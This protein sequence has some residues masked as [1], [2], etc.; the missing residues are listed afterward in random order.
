[1]VTFGPR[2]PDSVL[3]MRGTG[4][5][6]FD[7]VVSDLERSLAFYR[8]LLAPLGYVRA[9]EIVGERGERVVYL[10]ETSDP[11]GAPIESDEAAA[12]RRAS[13]AAI[14]VRLGFIAADRAVPDN[15]AV[16]VLAELLPADAEIG[17]C[18]T[19]R[20][21]ASSDRH[22]FAQ[23]TGVF[24]DVASFYMNQSVAE[25]SGGQSL[26]KA[27]RRELV[28]CTQDALCW[29]ASR[30]R[31]DR[32]DSVTLYSVPFGDILGAS[33]RHRRRGVVE[34][35]ID[36]GP[37]LSFRVGPDTADALKTRIDRAAQSQ[38]A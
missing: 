27:P 8:A 28:V 36:D 34:V 26:L 38:Q 23:T 1:L 14:L 19:C 17:L 22:P 25:V 30:V 37:T 4:V 6:H 16:E 13:I 3:E 11:R 24:P 35:W 18:L 29:T 10:G 12:A 9:S 2:E 5:D 33:V 15:P 32:E 21:F 20:E 7:L 31:S